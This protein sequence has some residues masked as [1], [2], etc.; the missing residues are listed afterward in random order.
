[1]PKRTQS[2][3][4]IWDRKKAKIS[5]VTSKLRRYNLNTFSIVQAKALKAERDKRYLDKKKATLL[6]V[7]AQLEEVFHLRWLFRNVFIEIIAQ[8][9]AENGRLTARNDALQAENGRLKERLRTLFGQRVRCYT[10][11][12]QSKAC[13]LPPMYI[14]C[15]FVY[16][17]LHGISSNF[18]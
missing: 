18:A 10:N 14:L 7:N 5:Q 2:D 11:T 8:S 12:T 1:M 4:E 6:A 15:I 3:E 16:L 9:V 17:Y 13:S